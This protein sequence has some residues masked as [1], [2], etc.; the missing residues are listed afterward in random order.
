MC[1]RLAWTVDVDVAMNAQVFDGNCEHLQTTVMTAV[2][3]GACISVFKRGLSFT[4][5]CLDQPAWL[6][7]Q[8][9]LQST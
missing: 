6:Q 4:C 1:F 5:I 8:L 9:G 2:T 3:T 7:H